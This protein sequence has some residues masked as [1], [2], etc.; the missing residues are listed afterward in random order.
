MLPSCQPYRTTSESLSIL[1]RFGTRTP[2][3]VTPFSLSPSWTFTFPSMSTV[4]EALHTRTTVSSVSGGHFSPSSIGLLPCTSKQYSGEPVLSVST[5]NMTRVHVSHTVSTLPSPQIM[6][7]S[8]AHLTHDTSG[9]YTPKTVPSVPSRVMLSEIPTMVASR[10]PPPLIPS[11]VYDAAWSS[12][13]TVHNTHVQATD[14]T[15][16]AS[17]ISPYSSFGFEHMPAISHT[18]PVPSLYPYSSLGFNPGT[19]AHR[20][21]PLSVSSVGTCVQ[22]A[23]PSPMPS[24]VSHPYVTPVCPQ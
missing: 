7:C 12:T 10:S 14:Y 4:C 6:E 20:T 19:S 16:P 9:I 18:R 23:D 8:R 24:V 3:S 1:P 21:T 2:T 17:S 22:I 15:R 11:T 13:H 5:T